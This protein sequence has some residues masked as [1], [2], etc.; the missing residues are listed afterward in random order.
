MQSHGEV[1]EIKMNEGFPKVAKHAKNKKYTKKSAGDTF[2]WSPPSTCFWG[3]KKKLLKF[4]ENPNL[5]TFIF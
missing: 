5:S 3:K 1:L 2:I 4:H